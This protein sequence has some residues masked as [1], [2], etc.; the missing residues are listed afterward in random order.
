MSES[1]QK[2]HI[3]YGPPGSGK[4]TAIEGIDGQ[5]IDYVSVGAL[6]RNELRQ[7]TALSKRMRAYLETVREYPRCIMS[8]I[9][10]RSLSSCVAENIVFD[11]FPKWPRELK[12]LDDMLNSR[13][14]IIP[15][16]VA[17]F[18]VDLEQASQRVSSRRI[19]QKCDM[20]APDMITCVRCGSNTVTARTDDELVSFQRRFTDYTETVPRLFSH[21]QMSGFAISHIDT[22]SKP[23]EVVLSELGDILDVSVAAR[24]VKVI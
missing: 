3:L 5:E 2:V 21:L 18:D 17:V 22:T 9:I 1:L 20:Q 8:R 10:E 19:C 15:G 7:D 16:T 13:P 14:D 12:I 4:T 6:F 11:G 23:P 24:E